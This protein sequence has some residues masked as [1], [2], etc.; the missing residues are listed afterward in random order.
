MLDQSQ[1]DVFEKVDRADPLIFQIGITWIEIRQWCNRPR[2]KI[3]KDK[4]KKT[5]TSL[6]RFK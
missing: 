4:N 5:L 6:L 2:C 1:T 3:D